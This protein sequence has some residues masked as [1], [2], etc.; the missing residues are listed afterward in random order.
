MI[1]SQWYLA[2]PLVLLS[3]AIAHAG[4]I[5]LPPPAATR[6]AKAD[7][8]I[9]GKVEALEP[10]DVMVGKV[11]YRIAVVKINDGIKGIK[12]EKTLR[13]GFVPEP[14]PKDDKGPRIIRTGARPVQLTAGQEG[15]FILKKQDKED[16]YTIG[17]VVGYYIN[18]DKNDGFA[19]EVQVA[20]TVLKVS[21]NP[22]T[23]L[24]AKDADERLL[25]ASVLIEKYRAFQ[26]KDSKQMPI[27]AEESKLIMQAMAEADWKTPANYMS[28]R[29][30][31]MRL[32]QR[33]GV[34][35]KD[36]FITPP[37]S[38][39]YGSAVQT[40]VRD[41]AEKYRIQRYVAS[42]AK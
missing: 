42:D 24:K 14:M 28:L 27:D 36:G 16:F 41:N 32:F 17:G 13:I 1:R 9:V 31:P 40:W 25:A 38:G 21:E 5:P 20:K 4:V 8:V 22:L 11:A 6:I 18:S 7:A 39:D 30:N 34:T 37:A 2:V 12:T 26:G 3:A 10:Q 23:H 35:A 29:P 15:L 33:L 19:K